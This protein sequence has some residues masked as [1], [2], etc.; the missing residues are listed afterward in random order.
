MMLFSKIVNNFLRLS[1]FGKSFIILVWE[2]FKYASEIKCKIQV[3][4]DD[5]PHVNNYIPKKTYQKLE[6]KQYRQSLLVNSL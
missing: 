4:P 1:I 5:R 2:G 3:K 6:L